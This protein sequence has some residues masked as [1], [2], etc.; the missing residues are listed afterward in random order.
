MKDDAFLELPAVSLD[1][2]PAYEAVSYAWGPGTRWQRLNLLGQCYIPV[3]ETF[4]NAIPYL[5]NHTKA[6][7]LWI[8]QACINQESIADKNQQVPLMSEI[9]SKADRVMAWLGLKCQTYLWPLKGMIGRIGSRPN[10]AHQCV[11]KDSSAY[12]YNPLV[13]MIVDDCDY[14]PDPRSGHIRLSISISSLLCEPWFARALVFQ[15]VALARTVDLI[16]GETVMALRDLERLVGTMY[17]L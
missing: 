13:K 5:L 1:E 12:Y 9:F 14:C 7:Y 11:F 2:I 6:R 10:I 8:D 17:L 15:E 3:T 4:L 16:S